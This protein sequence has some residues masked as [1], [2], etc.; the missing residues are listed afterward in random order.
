ME[1]KFSYY[2]DLLIPLIEDKT[3]DLGEDFIVNDDKLK[4]VEELCCAIDKLEDEIN[5][6]KLQANF[7][8]DTGKLEIKI[9]CSDFLITN[10]STS[11]H[12]LLRYAIRFETKTAK[13]GESVELFF[14]FN[15]VWDYIG[16]EV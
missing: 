7:N 2:N 3:D 5:F 9:V 15:N 8:D 6:F 4:V 1:Q 11:F 16:D 10:K 14:E 12:T 13:V